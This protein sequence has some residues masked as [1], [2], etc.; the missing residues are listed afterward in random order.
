M[1]NYETIE[2]EDEKPVLRIFLNRPE[3]ANAMNSVMNQELDDVISKIRHD[4]NYKFIVLRGNGK[5][6]SA[7]ADLKEISTAFENGELDSS[8]IRDDQLARH[9]FLRKFDTLD[10]ITI[11]AIN[12]PMRGAGF[13]LAM[14]CDFRLMASSADAGLPEIDRGLFFSGGGTPRLVNLIGA[15]KAKEVIMLGE[16]ISADEAGNI[17]LVNQ[18]VSDDALDRSVDE[19]IEKLDKKS[20]TPLRLTKKIVN[21][22]IPRFENL[23]MY[24]PELQEMSMFRGEVQ[25]QM[26]EFLNSKNK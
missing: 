20:F 13:A 7:G 4:Q 23:L 21:A 15:S 22:S 17:G 26:T 1:W 18:V 25:E 11:A 10:L 3:K 12:G 14:V 5:Y 9:E 24:E 16:P 8:W 6:F 2:I 19:L